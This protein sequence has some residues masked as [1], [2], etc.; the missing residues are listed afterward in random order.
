MVFLHLIQIHYTI[1]YEELITAAACWAERFKSNPLNCVILICVL[2]FVLTWTFVHMAGD[3]HPSR[4]SAYFVSKFQTKNLL[5]WLFWFLYLPLSSSKIL[6]SKCPFNCL[7]DTCKY[8]YRYSIWELYQND[9]N[10]KNNTNE[11]YS[12]CPYKKHKTM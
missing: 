8:L 2:W 4:A 10:S 1:S 3:D 7:T 5:N 6:G 9:W 12:Q 11:F